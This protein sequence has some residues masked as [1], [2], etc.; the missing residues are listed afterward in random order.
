MF[1]GN[2][3]SQLV[4]RLKAAFVLRTEASV[5][6]AASTIPVADGSGKL[7]ADW[8]PTRGAR[9]YHSAAQSIPNNTSTILAF[10]S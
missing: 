1:E 8:M 6:P 4:D 7:A 10:D 9:V 2:T 3:L 5:T